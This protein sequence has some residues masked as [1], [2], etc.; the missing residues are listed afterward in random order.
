MRNRERINGQNGWHNRG[1]G[2]Q[3]AKGGE[4]LVS[5]PLNDTIKKGTQPTLRGI[6]QKT[7]SRFKESRENSSQYL[8]TTT[9]EGTWI[10][11]DS[12]FASLRGLDKAI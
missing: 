6:M 12:N 4:S 7:L 2:T 10:Q 11:R 3:G 5:K 8:R 1:S 9:I